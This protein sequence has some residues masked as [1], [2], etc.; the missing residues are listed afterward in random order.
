MMEEKMR[1]RARN[2]MRLI[3]EAARYGVQE[4]DEPLDLSAVKGDEC[5]IVL[6]SDDPKEIEAFDRTNYSLM[7]NNQ[8]MVCKKLLFSLD[9]SVKTEHCIVW[10]VREFVR[11]SGEAVLADILERQLSL[12]LGDAG[13]GQGKSSAGESEEQTGASIP[14]L[15]IKVNKQQAERI[16]GIQGSGNLK[17][18]PHW[19]YHFV[20][21]GEQVYKDHRV[22]FDAEGDGAINAING[23]KLEIDPRNIEESGV[24]VNAEMV[25]PHISKE[26]ATERIFQELEERLTQRVRIKQVK[27]DAIFYEEKVIKPDRKNITIDIRE[28]FIPVWQIRGKKIVEINANTGEV[29]SVPMDEGVEI[30]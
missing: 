10:G 9:E 13:E 8:E 5:V 26:D 3:L 2:A 19:V 27:G 14:H 18:M 29:L 20:S 17:F 12:S 4:V 11:Y 21:S 15:P 6:C 24:A 7:V 23:I 1:E 30:L 28:V 25:Q 16:A 22:P